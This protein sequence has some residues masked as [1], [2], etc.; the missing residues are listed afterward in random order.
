MKQFDLTKEIL[1]WLALIWNFLMNACY[2]I[3]KNLAGIFEDGW[4]LLKFFGKWVNAHY[5][6]DGDEESDENRFNENEHDR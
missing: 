6:E 3:V 1:F 4:Q 5:S 2:V